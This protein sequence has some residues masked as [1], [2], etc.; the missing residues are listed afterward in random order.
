MIAKELEISLHM[1]FAWARQQ[2]HEF[3]TTECLLLALL[4]NPS[5]QEALLTCG[6]KIDDLRKSLAEFIKGAAIIVP[7][8]EPLESQPTLAFQRV[9][10]RAIMHVQSTGDG[11]KEVTGVNVLVAIYGEKAS[12]AVYYL[13]QQGVTRLDVVNFIAASGAEKQNQ[14]TETEVKSPKTF[15]E[16]FI[17]AGGTSE[18]LHLLIAK[19]KVMGQV[20][21]YLKILD[22]KPAV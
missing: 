19:P 13:D 18:M 14:A 12:H 9:I 17:A 22:L 1:A 2:R 4:D 6:A 10:Q 8:L 5:A 7:G 16:A 21:A 3:V 11:K 15:P 20:V